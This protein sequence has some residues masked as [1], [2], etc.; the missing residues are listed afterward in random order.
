LEILEQI[1]NFNYETGKLAAI[2]LRSKKD[3]R[4]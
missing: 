1:R 3:P 2:I 4:F